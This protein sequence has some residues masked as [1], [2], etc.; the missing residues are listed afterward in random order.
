MHVA[1]D[2]LAVTVKDGEL[3]LLLGRRADPPYPGCWALP[4]R[5]VGL[6]ESAETAVRK[7]LSEMVKAG[8]TYFEQLYTFSA[9]NRDPRGRVIS[10]AYLAVIPW[11]QLEAANV[12]RL[13][14]FAVRSGSEGMKL[15]SPD[16]FA[17]A[18]GDLAFDHGEIISLGI[19]RLRGKIEYSGIGFRFLNEPDA[20]PLG[21]LLA[22]YGA[23]LERTIDFS[24]FKRSIVSRYLETGRIVQTDRTDQSGRRGRGRPAVLYRVTD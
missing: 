11:K 20:F 4:G 6:E 10:V 16:G 12:S 13:S 1:V 14:R 3:Q 22:I 18:A 2:L 21:E 17:L 5:L 15:V 7:L 23:V 8:E 24:N 9:L 19:A